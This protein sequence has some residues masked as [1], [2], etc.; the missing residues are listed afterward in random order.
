IQPTPQAIALQC[1]GAGHNRWLLASAHPQ[2]ARLHLIGQKPRKLVAEPPALVM[3]L[4]KYLEG[5]RV[6][7][8]RQP[9]WERLVEIGFARGARGIVP[10]T[11]WLVVEVMGQLSNLILH[12]DAGAILGALRQIGPERNRYRTIAPH[13]AYLYPPPQTRVLGT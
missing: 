13:A 9:Q 10:G 4:R 8:V 12:D 11:T 5:A 1:Y 6:C 7:E 3:L 2:F